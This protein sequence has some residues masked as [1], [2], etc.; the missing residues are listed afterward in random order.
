M[1]P[2]QDMKPPVKDRL[3]DKKRISSKVC[4]DSPESE[5]KERIVKPK[6]D[7]DERILDCIICHNQLSP[8]VCQV[9]V[10]FVV[11]LI[12]FC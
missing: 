12:R 4:Y 3:G 6:Y 2:Y 7:M 5:D 11:N 9:T 10:Y 1:D 8:P